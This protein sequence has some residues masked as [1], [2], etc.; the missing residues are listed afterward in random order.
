MNSITFF[1]AFLCTSL[2]FHTSTQSM[3]TQP[4][5]SALS[6]Q[7]Q[8]LH[9]VITR[10]RV[11][12]YTKYKDWYD[13][14]TEV[15]GLDIRAVEQTVLR[16]ALGWISLPYMQ[17]TT[18]KDPLDMSDKD[19]MNKLDCISRKELLQEPTAYP[20]C[21][22]NG[23]TS[24]QQREKNRLPIESLKKIQQCADSFNPL[25]RSTLDIRCICAQQNI[26]YEQLIHFWLYNPK[27]AIAD[28]TENKYRLIE[29]H[30][31]V[32]IQPEY[33]MRVDSLN[34][35]LK[36]YVAQILLPFNTPSDESSIILNESTLPTI[37]KFIASALSM[38]G[39]IRIP[40]LHLL[41][42]NDLLF[43]CDTPLSEVDAQAR[44]L[45]QELAY[46]LLHEQQGWYYLDSLLAWCY[47]SKQYYPS[48]TLLMRCIALLDH[49]ECTTVAQPYFDA[50]ACT[51]A[52][53]YDVNCIATLVEYN[54][55][56]A[57]G[58]NK[59]LI[60]AATAPSSHK[61]YEYLSTA[62]LQYLQRKKVIRF[63]LEKGADT[64]DEALRAFAEKLPSVPVEINTIDLFLAKGAHPSNLFYRDDQQ[65][66]HCYLEQVR[67]EGARKLA[68]F[69]LA[70]KDRKKHPQE[71]DDFV[72][73][74]QQGINCIRT[75][76]HDQI[77]DTT[78]SAY[79]DALTTYKLAFQA[80]QTNDYDPVRTHILGHY[81]KEPWQRK[82]LLRTFFGFSLLRALIQK[83]GREYGWL[84]APLL[85]T[86]SAAGGLLIAY[87]CAQ[88]M[89]LATS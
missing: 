35:E 85:S 87:R 40:L 53:R 80:L 31:A 51:A 61:E 39:D 26:L 86:M 42:K 34:T 43:T 57:Q 38:G 13:T 59:A 50:L 83:V 28:N 22:W 70:H 5:K 16:H 67:Y 79:Q 9:D 44:A 81:N 30:T 19:M 56:S 76:F 45:S 25:T 78:Q 47:P 10:L 64:L 84:K 2:S 46:W 77:I 6:W 66:W 3:H 8:E 41:I 14:G 15:G 88:K 48:E 18:Q 1:L 58:L 49:Y 69:L 36:R 27:S 75:L 63:L 33:R 23:T 7:D 89:K 72:Y 62:R 24:A 17:D 65:Q 60:A 32:E 54:L 73:I 68:H 11:F 37:K 12:P 71:P 74:Q 29:K 82:T 4:E 21:S 52:Q 55:V 20:H